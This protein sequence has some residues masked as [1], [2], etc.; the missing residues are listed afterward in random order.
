MSCHMQ[1][2]LPE[3]MHLSWPKLADGRDQGLP[4]RT[5]GTTPDEFMV[6]KLPSNVGELRR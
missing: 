6:L 5:L 2:R 3:S 1:V 4:P